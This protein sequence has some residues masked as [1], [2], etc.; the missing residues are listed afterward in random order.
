MRCRCGAPGDRTICAFDYCPTCAET[1]LGPIR[2]R[3]IE[4]E[5]L[6]GVGIRH[7][8]DRPDHGAGFCDLRCNDCGALWVGRVG[9][10]CAYC[11]NSLLR[12]LTWQRELLLDVELPEPSDRRYAQSVKAWADRLARGVEAGIVTEIDARRAWSRK[13]VAHVAA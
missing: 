4:R 11:E 9:D 8:V 1:L 10:P 3:V 7:G 13:V 2:E 12:M 5:G 6:E